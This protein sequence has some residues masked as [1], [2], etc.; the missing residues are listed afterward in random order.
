MTTAT[1]VAKRFVETGKHALVL[2]E[3]AIKG[4]SKHVISI[5][6]LLCSQQNDKTFRLFWLV[7]KI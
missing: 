4:Q 5:M 1:A 6:R 7:Q 3:A 2:H